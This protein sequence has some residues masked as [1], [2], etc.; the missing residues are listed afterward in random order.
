MTMNST[1]HDSPR[2]RG[3]YVKYTCLRLL[4]WAVI[5]I[6]FWVFGVLMVLRGD[7]YAGVVLA[8]VFTSIKA[9]FEIFFR[10]ASSE[11]LSLARRKIVHE[12]SRVRQESGDGVVLDSVSLEQPFSVDFHFNPLGQ[13]IY[14][15]TQGNHSIKFASRIDDA[16]RLVKEVFRSPE[17][18]PPEIPQPESASRKYHRR[19]E[20]DG[21]GER[22]E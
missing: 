9:G 17:K 19:A 16:E 10:V 8:A 15:V 18:W 7:G 5:G 3:D 4:L 1:F 11:I 13:P 20:P 6:P 12:G 14:K 21:F 2:I 22:R